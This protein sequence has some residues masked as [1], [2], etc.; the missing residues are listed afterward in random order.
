M[1]IRSDKLEKLQHIGIDVY[2]RRG[3]TVNCEPSVSSPAA[4]VAEQPALSP[5]VNRDGRPTD[6]VAVAEQ[7]ALSPET[8]ESLEQEVSVCVKCTLST[9][10]TQTVFGVGNPHAEWMLVGEAP[11]SEEDL[12]G[13]PFVGR[14]GKLLDKMLAAIGLDRSTVYI[15]NIIK[16]RPPQNRNPHPVEV[17]SCIPY[18]HRQIQHIQPKLILALGAVAASN[19]LSTQTAVGKLRGKQHYLPG[20]GIPVIVTYHPA[21]LLRSPQQKTC[22]VGRFT[23]C[24]SCRGERIIVNASSEQTLLNFRMMRFS[25]I[26][27]VYQIE[28]ESYEIPWGKAVFTSCLEANS[29]CWLLC[30]VNQILGYVIANIGVRECHLLNVCVALLH[31]NKG[32]GR[33]LMR[34]MLDQAAVAGARRAFLEVCIDNHDAR[35]LYLSEGFSEIGIRKNY[36][37]TRKGRVDALVMA[38]PV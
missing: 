28:C 6:P 7:P 32:Y 22:R 24:L 10:R 30:E 5:A 17:T 38:R 35:Q 13:E 26:E 18:L 23:V 36:Y 27:P 34:F 3:Q 15:A 2:V 9:T 8:W 4:T 19:L 14:A 16:C 11:G 33:Q 25:D 21:Y 20:S 37:P 1:G 31:R 12:R 29:K